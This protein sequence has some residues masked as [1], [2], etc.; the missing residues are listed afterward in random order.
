[1]V[2]WTCLRVYDPQ[3]EDENEDSVVAGDRKA[4]IRGFEWAVPLWRVWNIDVLK[5]PGGCDGNDAR[6]R[7][8]PVIAAATGAPKVRAEGFRTS[9]VQNFETG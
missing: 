1:V 4:D 8:H 3:G 9:L 6:H 7:R 2:W 5:C